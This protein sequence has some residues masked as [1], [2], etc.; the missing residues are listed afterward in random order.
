MPLLTRKDDPQPILKVV[1]NPAE[2]DAAMPALL[3]I[4]EQVAQW[5][6][7]LTLANAAAELDL[8]TIEFVCIECGILAHGFLRLRC[9]IAATTSWSLSAASAAGSA[10]SGGSWRMSETTAHLVDHVIR[11]VPVR[12]CV[13]VCRLRLPIP[14]RM[15]LAAQPLLMTLVL[16]VVRQVITRF[17][18]DQAVQGDNG[19][20]MLIRHLRLGTVSK[21]LL[22]VE[23]NRLALLDGRCRLQDR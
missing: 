16:Q 22:Q 21:L 14:L 17:L 2:P 12:Q 20:V 5:E 1:F 10:L 19:A 7:S 15:L 18:L 6:R 8:A 23:S 11:H 13:R 3:S 4:L 9:A